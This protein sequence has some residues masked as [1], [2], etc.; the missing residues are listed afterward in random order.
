MKTPDWY[1]QAIAEQGALAAAGGDHGKAV[2]S[3]IAAISAHPEFL[4]DMIGRDLGRW[5]KEHESS[6]DLFQASLFPLIPVT[7]PVTPS[8][9]V[10]V[11]QMT[12]PDLDNA[13][14]MLWNRTQNTIDGADRSREAFA[15]FYDRVRPLL[16][17]GLTVTEVIGQL[18]A[19]KAA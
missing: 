18:A 13:R 1:R 14:S 10:K 16:K 4:P 8:K 5:V 15:V 2:A 7:M 3:V 12:G 6:G 19:G 9:S 11:S 17:D